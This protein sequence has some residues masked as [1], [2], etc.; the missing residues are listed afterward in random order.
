MK[1]LFTLLLSVSAL[2]GTFAQEHGYCSTDEH[3]E[4]LKQ[5]FPNAEQLMAEQI[6]RI[7]S[8]NIATDRSTNGII[9]VV[10]HVIHDGGASNISYEQIESAIQQL[11][12]DYNG[13]NPDIGNARNTATAPFAPEVGVLELSF[14]LAKIDPNGNCT[15]GVQRRNS[16]ATINA[17]QNIK[18]YSGGG[19]DQWPR[20]SYMNIWVVS[21]IESSGPGITLGYAQ[22]PYFGNANTYGVV[23]RHDA[24]GTIGTANGDRTFT[25]ELGHCLGLL[26]TFQD[27]CHSQDCSDNGDYCCDTPPQQE[28]FWTCNQ[29]QNSCDQI[30]TNDTYGFNA[31]DQ[32]ENFMSYSPCQYMFSADQVDIMLGNMNTLEWMDSLRGVTNGIATGVGSAP[33]LCAAEFSSTETIICAGSTVDF[34]D[35][36]YFD[37]ATRDWTFD[38][39]TPATSTDQ[40]PTIT[41]NTPGVYDVELEVSDGS[42]S[43]STTETAHII[44]LA[45][46]GISLPYSEGFETYSSIPDNQNW[47]VENEDGVAWNIATGVGSSG[48]QCIKLANFGNT[49]QSKD[50]ILSGPIDLSGVDPTDNIVFNFKYAYKKRSAS[51]DEWLRFYISKDCGETWVLRKNIH[52]DDLSDEVM[53]SSFNSPAEDDWTQVDITNISE[54]YFVENFRFKIQYEN[55]IGNNI[56]IDDI[57]IS[58]G[59]MANL[60]EN[61]NVFNLSVYPNPAEDDFTVRLDVAK[62]GMYSVELKNTLGQTI[63]NVFN[64]ELINGIKTIDYDANE[65]PAGVYFLSVMHDGNNQTIKFIKN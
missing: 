35:L 20:D 48:T 62:A 23:I 64:G 31:L 45:N 9:P 21:S 57:N 59:A 14:E 17:Y 53:S 65:I 47:L 43:V 44:V 41:Y 15:N 32:W 52:D 58:S 4:E 60:G 19:L 33:Q 2:S 37:I 54:T 12:E 51:N 40:N 8:T 27:G 22:F 46:P 28:A 13:T 1:K 34:T 39:G 42:S 25:H 18:T 36:S 29:T 26:H 6:A 11:N 55:D 50:E 16:P 7:R 5:E 49:D 30:P 63:S 61:E 3:M 56:F 10:V 38:G 24:F